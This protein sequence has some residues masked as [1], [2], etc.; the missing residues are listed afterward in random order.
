MKI[1]PKSAKQA[2]HKP[3]LSLYGDIKDLTLAL[4][5]LRGNLDGNTGPVG[6]RLRTGAL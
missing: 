6:V 3:T 1:E 4:R 2:Y 5:R